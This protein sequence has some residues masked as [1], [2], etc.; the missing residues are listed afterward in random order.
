MYKYETHLHTS[1]VSACSRADVR[2]QMEFYK[3]LGYD[4]IFITN[5]FVDGNGLCNGMKDYNEKIEF[6]FTDFE[7]AKELEKEIGIKVFCG[8]EMTHGGTDFLVYGPDKKWYL[9]HPVIENM[10]KSEELPYLRSHGALVVQ[11]HPF[12]ED[13]WIDHIRLY[14]RCVDGIEIINANRGDFENGMAKHYAE[15]YGLLKLAGSDNHA[16]KMQK[17]LAGMMSAVP[18]ENEAH[19]I[20]LCR[21]GKLEIFHNK[22]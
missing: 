7:K 21:E 17:N 14:P 3:E 12:R 22:A 4:G 1:G 18:I 10:E 15:S 19:F 8:V 16:G 6:F 2:E 9:D 11:A 13:R 20:T 5:H